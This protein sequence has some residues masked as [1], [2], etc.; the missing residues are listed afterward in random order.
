MKCGF[1]R[2]RGMGN[3]LPRAWKVYGDVVFCAQCRRARYRLRSITMAVVEPIGVGQ[4]LR[5]ALEGSW[6]RTTP[7]NGIWEA[8]IV[9]R[10]P[11]VRVLIRGR[12]WDLRLKSAAWYGGQREAYERIAYG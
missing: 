12:W 11:V 1:C 9:E 3:R 6:S 8:K 10:Q 7:R 4:E 2:R 5:T